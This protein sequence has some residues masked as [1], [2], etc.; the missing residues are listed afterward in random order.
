MLVFQTRIHVFI[1]AIWTDMALAFGG[2][3]RPHGNSIFR[4]GS[5]NLPVWEKPL[6]AAG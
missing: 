6:C 2:L 4:C 1:A 5:M 3:H